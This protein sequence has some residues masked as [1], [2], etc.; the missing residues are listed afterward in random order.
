MRSQRLGS[1]R[2][3]IPMRLNSQIVGHETSER[4]QKM[5]SERET[6]DTQSHPWEYAGEI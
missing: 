4:A 6:A 2:V 5:A 1:A 3:K